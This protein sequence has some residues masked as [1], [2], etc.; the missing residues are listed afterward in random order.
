MKTPSD[1]SAWFMLFLKPLSSLFAPPQIGDSRLWKSSQGMCCPACYV[2]PRMLYGLLS[3]WPTGMSIRRSNFSHRLACLH[4][5][6]S[7]DIMESLAARRR[8]TAQAQVPT[9]RGFTCQYKRVPFVTGGEGSSVIM[10]AQA[11][12]FAP[13]PRLAYCIFACRKQGRKPVCASML[14]LTVRSFYFRSEP[15]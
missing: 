7:Q 5:L 15:P 9:W 2:V 8:A 10:V 6:A 13:L 12:H 4:L 14:T 11:S 3:A 1:T